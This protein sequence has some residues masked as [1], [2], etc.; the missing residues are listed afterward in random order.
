MTNYENSENDLGKILAGLIMI[1]IF[2]LLSWYQIGR[3]SL[4]SYWVIFRVWFIPV[5]ALLITGVWIIGGFILIFQG[6]V[7]KCRRLLIR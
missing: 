7:S 2:G 5:P 6:I 3:I 4:E 1:I